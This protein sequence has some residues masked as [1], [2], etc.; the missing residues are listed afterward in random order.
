MNKAIS[1]LCAITM[2]IGMVFCCGATASAEEPTILYSEE[3]FDGYSGIENTTSG[4]IGYNHAVPLPNGEVVKLGFAPSNA[5]YREVYDEEFSLGL[6]WNFKIARISEVDGQKY[7]YQ[8][9]GK[10]YEI[11]EELNI[12]NYPSEHTLTLRADGTYLLEEPFGYFSL[13]DTNGRLVSSVDSYAKVTSYVYVEN[14]LKEIRYSD[15][16][17]FRVNYAEN[18]GTETLR[19]F[20]ISSAEATSMLTITIANDRLIR[21]QDAQAGQLLFAYTQDGLLSYFLRDESD[22]VLQ[23]ETSITGKRLS[24]KFIALDGVTTEYNYGYNAEGLLV[25]DTTVGQG[26][27]T[28]TY[29][30]DANGNLTT[31]R[32]ENFGAGTFWT[33]N[34]K[35]ELGQTV[36]FSSPYG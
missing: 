3:I 4:K 21:M 24:K 27:V 16:S 6:G 14:G 31:I 12:V 23:Y 35:N 1:N 32:Q 13:F 22:R 26:T 29:Q 25:T 10:V 8:T 28:Y 19:C 30:Q 33:A 9:N 7:L 11:D 36:S 2:V 15:G 17:V 20:Y 34:T 18:D 5:V